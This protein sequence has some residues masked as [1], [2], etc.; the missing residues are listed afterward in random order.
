M[1]RSKTTHVAAQPSTAQ[2]MR[3]SSSASANM[4]S[5]INHLGGSHNIAPPCPSSARNSLPAANPGILGSFLG[6]NHFQPPNAPIIN[7]SFYARQSYTSM[8]PLAEPGK[9]MDVGDFLSMVRDDIT[10]MS[11]EHTSPIGIR[12]SSLLAPHNAV[13]FAVNPSMP[14][15]T[16]GSMT[17]APTLETAP[18]SRSNS[19]MNDNVIASQLEMVRIQ[20]QR[21]ARG[22]ARQDSIQYSPTG[23]HSTMLGK[24]S[25]GESDYLG[26]GAASLPTSFHYAYQ[27][28]TMD[29][30]NMAQHQHAMKKS[31]SRS[32]NESATSD[33]AAA[34]P[35]F[36][37]AFLSQHTSMERS[38]STES[39]ASSRSLKYRAK[40]A[41]ARQNVNAKSR[42]LQPKPAG[43]IVKKQP[44]EP[45]STKPKDGK[46]VIAKAKY[47]RPK[48][49]KVKCNQCNENP[50]GFRGEHELRRHTEAKH[51]SMVRKWVCRDP[52]LEGIKHA[53]H[54]IRSLNDCKQCTQQKQYGAYYNAA[55]HLR[56]THFKIKP[57]RKGANGA[58]GANGAKNGQKGSNG[59]NK[60]DD[61]KRGGK[62]GG[63][64]PPMSELKLWMKEVIVPMD[65]ADAFE[66]SESVG[67][68]DA[69][70][71]ENDF[72]DVRYGAQS[73]LPSGIGPEA[74]DM[75]AITGVGGGFTDLGSIDP[76]FQSLQGELFL[77]TSMYA[78][79]MQHLPISSSGFD[80]NAPSEQHSQ[81]TLA[82]SMMSV[83]SHSYTSPVS[84]TA[85]ITQTGLADP[86]LLHPHQMPVGGDV[87]EMSFDL[88][89][90]SAH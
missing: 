11:P 25:A 1:K 22:N 8:E 73:S 15:S 85:T 86:R 5:R 54:A 36:S 90:A 16:C 24:R 19:A 49:P 79:T 88:M 2:M 69:E 29:N 12:S 17:S 20:S 41:L 47:E 50:E 71:Q 39:S 28:P 27:P 44:V 56:R 13:P 75:A 18:M 38:V 61:E 9:E 78:S 87:N 70:D 62:G 82:A 67:G 35:E 10:M 40:E 83:D 45:T 72:F 76:S 6:Q 60:G 21:S 14:P 59:G 43:A 48:H 74:Y 66:D 58:N 46:A 55:A 37:N 89:F 31:D 33:K 26:L 3:S 34:A 53:E 4:A 30:I 84:S 7:D 51:K 63:D 81:H 32:S 57:A 68:V 80:F 65:Q 77:D 64:W 23:H 42:Q 52:S